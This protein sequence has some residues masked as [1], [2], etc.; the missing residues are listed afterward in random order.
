M[1]AVPF[2]VPLGKREVAGDFHRPYETQKT[3][4]GFHRGSDTGW[5]RAPTYG[6]KLKA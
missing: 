3:S 4:P 6:Y 2:N 5:G 1:R